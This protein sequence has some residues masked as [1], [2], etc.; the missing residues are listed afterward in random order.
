MHGSMKPHEVRK[1]MEQA[2]IFLFTS[3][4]NEGWGAVLGEAMASGCAVVTSH[5]IGATPFLVQHKENGLIYKTGKYDSFERNVIRLVNDSE[6]RKNLSDNAIL[7]MRNQWNAKTG[8][9]RLYRLCKE[10]LSGKTPSIYKSG[11]LSKAE[12]LKNNWFKDDTI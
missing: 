12:L 6:F 4:F 9:E 1:F 2:D 11:P 7:T 5:G 10:L 3:D 8:A